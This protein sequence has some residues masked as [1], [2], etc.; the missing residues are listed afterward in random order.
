MLFRS[1]GGKLIQYHGWNDNLISPHNSVDYFER[2]VAR[3]GGRRDDIQNF[4]RLFMVPGM[5]HCGGGPGPNLFDMQSALESWVEKDEA[6]QSVIAEH[7]T[8]GTPDRSR[9]LCPYPTTAVY[10]G[11]GDSNDA[12]NFACR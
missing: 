6:P 2:V 5:G 10:K 11:K 3:N 9:P 7:R 1:H 12:G 4:Y 8:N